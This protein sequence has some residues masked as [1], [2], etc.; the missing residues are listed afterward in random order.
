MVDLL[1]A[2]LTLAA[3]VAVMLFLSS[4]YTVI[5]LTIMPALFVITLG[6]TKSIKT[7]TKRAAKATGQVADVAPEDINALTVIKIFTREENASLPFAA[8]VATNRPPALPAP[9]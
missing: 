5:A 6:Y 3:I 1:A 9:T 7:A 8:S 2:V 4:A